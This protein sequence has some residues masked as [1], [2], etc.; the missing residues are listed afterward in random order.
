MLTVGGLRAPGLRRTP[1]TPRKYRSGVNADERSTLAT[2]VCA[3]FIWR[4]GSLFHLPLWKSF[5]PVNVKG[6]AMAN[7]QKRAWLFAAKENTGRH[8]LDSGSAYGR[9]WE[10]N[11]E[12]TLK[13]AY[14]WDHKLTIASWGW[15][16]SL[17]VLT[18]LT[19]NFRIDRAKT[20]KFHRFAYSP[21]QRNNSW[22]E[23]LQEWVE[24][25]G[26]RMGGGHNTY[27]DESLLT[28]CVLMHCFEDASGDEWHAVSVHTGCD[29]RGGYS[30]P[31]ICRAEDTEWYMGA[32]DAH[33]YCADG[34][35]FHTDDGYH[36]YADHTSQSFDNDHFKVIFNGRGHW[37][38][39]ACCK[40]GVN[41]V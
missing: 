20:A 2:Q 22:F 15:E 35:R 9:H 33:M 10:R 23:S 41:V 21:A 27:N 24:S 38:R 6:F 18:Y 12:L 19:E 5:H 4:C 32:A 25:R 7:Y 28:Q 34:H 36:W 31:F 39:C 3:C 1:Y 40:K 16:V 14:S 29:V 26:G 11:K 17:N 8:F 37:L 13:S 30:R